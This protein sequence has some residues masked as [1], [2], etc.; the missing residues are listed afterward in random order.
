MS[1]ASADQ[2]TTA[3]VHGPRWGA[4]AAEW[5]ELSAEISRPA[6]EA[7]ADATAIGVGTQVL[8]VGCGSG[9]FCSVATARG[10]AAS[11]IDAADEM[12]AVARRL[13]P[14]ADLRVGPIERLPWD[15]HTFDV[16]T[17]F[18]ALQFAADFLTA[19]IE[20]ARVTRPGGHVAV[21]NW[22]RA[23][24]SDMSS[25]VGAMRDLLPPSPPASA[26]SDPPA[27]GEPGVLEDLSR[28]AGLEPVQAAELDV[29]F[30]LPDRAA[31][32]SALLSAGAVQPAIEHVGEQAVRD[33]VAEAGEPFRRPDGSYLLQ[34]RFRYVISTPRA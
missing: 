23:A 21:C 6:W 20:A 7:V 5:A 8:D 27:I 11:G 25:V 3:G 33:R 13:A 10:A 2:W 19:L 9:E 14:D 24:D 34:N 30:A 22:S 31:L 26:R 16:V 28:Q 18:N 17:A 4:R 1:E 15:D 12:I 29:P 32:E